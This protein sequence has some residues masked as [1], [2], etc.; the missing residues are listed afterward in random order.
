L[1]ATSFYVYEHWRTDTN[2]PFYVG[3]GH[4]ARAFN[5]H[6]GRN[7]LHKSVQGHL[8]VSDARIEIKTIA[9]GLSEENAFALE[10]E[11]IAFWINSG[12]TLANLSAGGQGASGYRH[13]PEAIAKAVAFHTGRK[14][15]PQTRER[16]S[17][18]ARRR[19]VAPERIEKMAMVNRGK[20]RVFTAEHRANIGRRNKGKKM[21]P[22]VAEALRLS[23]L[24]KPRPQTP[25]TRAKI[26]AA[27]TGRKF[28]PLSA[29]HR[30]AIS[31]GNKG[32][33]KTPEHRAKISAARLLRVAENK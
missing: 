33:I 26:S 14:R 28:G 31:A 17:A 15:S 22:Q 29:E 6:H 23:H 2:L 13:T 1:S 12:V 25:E 7:H 19:K 10:R 18:K 4:G 8:A 21:L 16:I 30:A 27:R 5:M 11:K 32:K 24:G 3:K 9:D 20:K